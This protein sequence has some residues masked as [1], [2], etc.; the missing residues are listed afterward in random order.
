MTRL[1]WETR[2]V[3]LHLPRDLH[4][5]YMV[6]RMGVATSA[7]VGPLFYGSHN[8]ARVGFHRLA[9]LGLLRV[10]ERSDPSKPSWYGLAPVAAAWVIEG[11]ECDDT[12]VR[13]VSGIRRMNLSMVDSRN[14]LWVSAVLAARAS[15]GRCGI[16]LVRPEWELR[17]MQTDRM[18]TVPDMQLVVS[19]R[20]GS[21]W[22][23]TWMIELDAGT[24]RTAVIKAKVEAYRVLRGHVLYG[25]QDWQLLFVVPGPRRARSV[26]QTV[27]AAGGSAFTWVAV[28]A[29]L[30][31]GRALDV[32][33]Y[34]PADF[35]NGKTA[36]PR[37]SLATGKP[38]GGPDQGLIGRSVRVRGG[39][40]DDA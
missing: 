11:M 21:D 2:G 33:L 16:D 37:A 10:F 17:R 25:A 8:T 19:H 6:G 7:H 24:E 35:G 26:A 1:P 13:V 34:A 28:E 4:I 22:L 18:R 38:I 14:R 23:H 9:K 15:E 27:A 32:V 40:H 36:R 3:R 5:A 31:D 12:E 30:Q 20:G 39:S 29:D